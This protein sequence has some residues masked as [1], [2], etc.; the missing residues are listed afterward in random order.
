MNIPCPAIQRYEKAIL[1]EVAEL[2]EARRRISESEE[3]RKRLQAQLES[4]RAER[5]KN[6]ARRNELEGAS[7]VA[8]HRMNLTPE[9]GVEEIEKVT[10][11][12]DASVA[13]E[14][15]LSEQI[16]QLAGAKNTDSSNIQRAIKPLIYRCEVASQAEFIAWLSATL[17]CDVTY[18]E[19]HNWHL[20]KMSFVYAI[21]RERA[22]RLEHEFWAVVDE[23]LQNPIVPL[24][25]R[26]IE[27][28]VAPGSAVCREVHG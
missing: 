10:V 13:K 27:L 19:G 4:E 9:K 11:K 28:P 1:D 26:P 21:Y 17:D 6:E 18:N 14:A 24:V 5:Q 22:R 20:F 16:G 25:Q 15:G 3:Q 8:L 12:I 2:K 23:T 7:A